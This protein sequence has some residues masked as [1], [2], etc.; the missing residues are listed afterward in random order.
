MHQEES[1]INVSS[2][3]KEAD[4]VF[5]L[6]NFFLYFVT[7]GGNFCL[8]RK[9]GT[10]E[11]E[12]CPT[13]GSIKGPAQGAVS[14]FVGR[15]IVSTVDHG[16]R[17]APASRVEYQTEDK[18]QA[19]DALQQPAD[20]ENTFL[21]NALY[22]HGEDR[23]QGHC[24]EDEDAEGQEDRCGLPEATGNLTEVLSIGP[25]HCHLR[26]ILHPGLADAAVIDAQSGVVGLRGAAQLI[27]LSA[28]AG[29][30]FSNQPDFAHEGNELCKSHHN[31]QEGPEHGATGDNDM[32]HIGVRGGKRIRGIHGLPIKEA[33]GEGGS[34]GLRRQ[35]LLGGTHFHSRG[36]LSP[37]LWGRRL[38]VMLP[39]RSSG[40]WPP[41]S[42][43]SV[44]ARML[45]TLGEQVQKNV[46]CMMRRNTL[47][48]GKSAD[49][50]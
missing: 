48:R 49:Q 30:G 6:F 7:G 43:T 4:K 25:A 12:D 13:D 46:T 38:S 31:T 23:H 36:L 29:L 11:G 27:G 17:A 24:A 39:C 40:A 32:T 5:P 35:S 37:G 15:R 34:G 22:T 47:M 9:D 21:H 16:L 20:V 41:A 33:G 1:G 45:G 26:G 14:R 18:E 3:L 2:K 19:C 28:A 50:L 42:P 8:C 44:S 10:D